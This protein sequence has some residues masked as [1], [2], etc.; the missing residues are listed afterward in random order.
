MHIR[1]TLTTLLIGSAIILPT[2]NGTIMELIFN[3]D[4]ETVD[5]TDW[6]QF[7]NIG[8]QSISA[9]VLRIKTHYRRVRFS[10]QT[11]AYSRRS[12]NR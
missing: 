4:F 2:A 7:Q 6:M 3:G 5:F 10:H 11:R 9:G 1:K 12:T 8:A